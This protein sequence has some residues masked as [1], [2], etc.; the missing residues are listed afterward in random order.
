MFTP[1]QMRSR[2]TN[3]NRLIKKDLHYAKRYPP[4]K[5]QISSIQRHV[6]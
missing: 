4:R 3:Y 6:K 1:L 2:E 5:L